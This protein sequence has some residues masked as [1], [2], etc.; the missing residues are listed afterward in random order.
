MR[1]IYSFD[2]FDNLNALTVEKIKNTI[3]ISFKP[4]RLSLNEDEARSMTYALMEI[5]EISTKNDDPCLACTERAEAE[6]QA[7]EGKHLR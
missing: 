5:L 6:Y 3:E 1:K 4:E 7:E 2:D